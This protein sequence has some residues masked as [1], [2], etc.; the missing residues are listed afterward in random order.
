MDGPRGA[1]MS[2]GKSAWGVRRHWCRANRPGPCSTPMRCRI[3]WPFAWLGNACCLAMSRKKLG[4]PG[5]SLCLAVRNMLRRSCTM[6]ALMPCSCRPPNMLTKRLC[7]KDFCKPRPWLQAPRPSKPC[8]AL[9]CALRCF[10]APWKAQARKFKPEAS[11]DFLACPLP[12]GH[13]ARRWFDRNCPV[14]C[15][16]VMKSVKPATTQ[17]SVRCWRSVASAVWRCV[18]AGASSAPGPVRASVLWKAAGCF[19]AANC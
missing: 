18:I 9:M 19:T 7:A 6:R 14:C 4:P 3:C 2:A 15:Q 8:S 13:S 5:V 11:P 17:R 1:R 10:D 12:T 16:A